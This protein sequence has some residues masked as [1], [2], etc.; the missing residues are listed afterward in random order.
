VPATGS[1][2]REYT[3]PFT[4]QW[5]QQKCDPATLSSPQRADADAAA[6]NLFAVH[7]LMHD[8]SYHLGFTEATWNLQTVNVKPGGLG[9]DAE[10]GNAMNGAATPDVRNNANQ[11]STPDGVPPT[12]NMFMFQ[13]RRTEIYAPCVDGDFDATFIAHE[14]GH[15]ISNRMIAGPDTR[16]NSLH[17]NAMGESWSDLIAME[18]LFEH[19][20]LPAG[21]TPFVTGG[22]VSGDPVSGV[23]NYDMSDSP[24]N[25]SNVGYDATNSVH[26]IGEIWSAVNADIR[27]A[28][29]DRYGAGDR[30]LQESCAAGRTAVDQCPGNRRWIQ[31][32]LDSFLLQATGEP[33]MLDMRDNLLAADQVRFDG[34]NADLLWRAFAHRGFGADAVSGPGDLDPTPSF[35]S[36]AGDN[37]EVTLRP[38]GAGQGRPV[39]LYVGDYESRSVPVADTDPATALPDTVS[40]V[41][42][43]YRFLAAGKGLGHTRLT[44]TITADTATVSPDMHLNVASGTNGAAPVGGNGATVLRADL[45]DDDED[46]FYMSGLLLQ[47]PVAQPYVTVDLA[48]TDAQV[49]TRVQVG[50]AQVSG[51]R[52]DALRSFQVE[53]C[54]ATAGADCATDAGFR[55]AYTSPAD[56]FPGGTFRPKMPNFTTR[57]FALDPTP[58][59]HLRIRSLTSQC[60]GNPHYT[61]ESDNDPRTTTV[62]AN[63]NASNWNEFQAFTD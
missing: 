16:L 17:G 15:A 59:T 57:S 28:M 48:G 8:W 45:L 7:N 26:S 4:D 29:L 18:F 56:A 23:R 31:L 37:V 25:F 22:Y 27:A 46:T 60:S 30:E 5:H 10:R 42:G 61:A 63:N 12:T 36:P 32:V 9:G 14:Y 1:A 35:R 54:D 62:C 43:E 38:T 33:S 19:G 47:Q 58:A 3:Y 2:S 24:L 55:V 41:P 34:A 53:A 50:S 52:F 51:Q 13:P 21:N 40:L 49:V 11:S 44:G 39:A 20:Y 6:V